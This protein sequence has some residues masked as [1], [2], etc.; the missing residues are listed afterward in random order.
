MIQTFLFDLGNVLVRF[1]HE[2]M[3]AQMGAV[4]G[5]S[6]QA[7]RT[8]RMES[9]LQWEFERGLLSEAQFHERIERA[10]GRSVDFDRL[11]HAG[12]DIFELTEEMVP[13]ID[14]LRSRGH[15]LVLLSNTSVSHFEFVRRSF[16]VLDRFDDFVLSYQVG[17]LKPQKEIFEAALDAIQCPPARC[18]YTDDIAEYVAAGRTHGLQADVFTTAEQL[19]EQLSARGVD[20]SPGAV[21]R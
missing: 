8:L 9:G 16:S 1:S 18:F 19:V 5:Q 7:M 2:R 21:C 13:V 20:I 11:V 15:R 12:A 4:C 17:A 3:C 14:A 10:V 6:P